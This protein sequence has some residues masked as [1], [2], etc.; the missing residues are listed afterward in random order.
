MISEPTIEENKRA[1]SAKILADV[2]TFYVVSSVLLH[3]S[4]A[5]VPVC[6]SKILVYNLIG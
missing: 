5:E 2:N 1:S 4:L 6:L 3:E